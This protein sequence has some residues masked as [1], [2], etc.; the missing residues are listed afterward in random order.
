MKVDN[1]IKICEEKERNN[2]KTSNLKM[3]YLLNEESFKNNN[4]NSMFNIKTFGILNSPNKLRYT[5]ANKKKIKLWNFQ[6][7]NKFEN[8]NKTFVNFYTNN[9]KIDFLSKFAGRKT[10]KALTRRKL[11]EEMNDMI[12][13][14]EKAYAIKQSRKN[15]KIK[16]I[17]DK[18]VSF[19]SL[20]S[21]KDDKHQKKSYSKNKN[22]IKELII[23]KKPTHIDEYTDTLDKDNSFNLIDIKKENKEDQKNDVIKVINKKYI[24]N[25]FFNNLNRTQSKNN[26]GQIQKIKKNF[27]DEVYLNKYK[28]Y[29]KSR[30]LLYN[31]G[32]FDMPLATNIIST[33]K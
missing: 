20:K 13:K 24:Q 16:E 9:F 15:I 28:N 12:E 33:E 21:E 22:F 8:R 32:Q 10:Q 27:F 5:S 6:Y 19:K 23:M 26:K 30:I 11:Q 2:L 1:Y 4:E 17:Y 14:I 29:D 25:W 3:N 18:L 7:M 31:T